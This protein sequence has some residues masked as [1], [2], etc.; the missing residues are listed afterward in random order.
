M[1]PLPRRSYSVPTPSS[2]KK[3]SALGSLADILPTAPAPAGKGSASKK[4][5]LQ[6]TQRD[7]GA[8]GKMQTIYLRSSD[9]DRATDLEYRTK[10]SRVVPGRIGLSLIL[11]AGLKLLEERFEKNEV[12][13]IALVADVA[14]EGKD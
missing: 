11:R 4:A 13:A 9:L 6:A 5:T 14:A 3:A 12:D 8:D 7:A 1:P 2:R 10:K